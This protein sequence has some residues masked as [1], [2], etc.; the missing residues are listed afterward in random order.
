MDIHG[1][2]SNNHTPQ[3]FGL[4]PRISHIFL[5]TRRSQPT[6]KRCGGSMACVQVNA[7]TSEHA[8]GQHWYLA[9]TCRMVDV[10]LLHSH[11]YA[12]EAVVGAVLKC[13]TTIAIRWQSALA[14]PLGNSPCA[15]GISTSQL[16]SVWFFLSVHCMLMNPFSCSL[17]HSLMD[18]S[19]SSG[20]MTN[21]QCGGP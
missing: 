15:L 9:V 3:P 4:E 14:A 20:Y 5:A 13:E 6:R 17:L 10:S 7:L 16:A 1:I 18:C 2:M 19:M 11:S 12:L 8:G 21:Y